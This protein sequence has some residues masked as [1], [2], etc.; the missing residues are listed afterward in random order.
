MY[1]T[2]RIK[3]E[4]KFNRKQV[5]SSTTSRPYEGSQHNPQSQTTTRHGCTPQSWGLGFSVIPSTIALN[6]QKLCEWICW[7]ETK[8]RLS[9]INVFLCCYSVMVLNKHHHHTTSHLF[10]VFCE[11]KSMKIG[12]YYLA[13][14]LVLVSKK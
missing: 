13:W 4:V 6:W 5:A 14:K 1:W 7:K 3:E 8:R 11:K 2:A 10:L 9:C 12:N